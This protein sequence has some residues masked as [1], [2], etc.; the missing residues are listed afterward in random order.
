MDYRQHRYLTKLRRNIMLFMFGLYFLLSLV[1]PFI[2]HYFGFFEMISYNIIR[3]IPIIVV[4][5]FT[6]KYNSYS[7]KIKALTYLMIGINLF[8]LI[9]DSISYYSVLYTYFLLFAMLMNFAVLLF[10]QVFRSEFVR[11]GRFSTF[12]SIAAAVIFFRYIS[13]VMFYVLFAEDSITATEALGL[14][15]L[16]YL[17]ETAIFTLQTLAMDAVY[18]EYLQ[19]FK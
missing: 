1:Y 7:T 18:D 16:V 11:G 8:L 4:G 2:A 5:V 10:A 17:I 12:V 6:L 14:T 19:F 13:I 15:V 9:V 3:T